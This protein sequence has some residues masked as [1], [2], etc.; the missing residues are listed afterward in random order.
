VW[1]Y[2]DVDGDVATMQLNAF[3]VVTKNNG[4]RDMETNRTKRK[5]NE[6]AEPGT[7]WHVTSNQHVGE[8]LAARYWD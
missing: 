5:K 6:K 8:W 3:S 4:E 1:S 7:P 2:S